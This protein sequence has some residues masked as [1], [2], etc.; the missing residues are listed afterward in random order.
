[1]KK[2]FSILVLTL[3]VNFLALAGGIGYLYGTKKLDKDKVHAIRD[4]VFPTTAPSDADATTQPSDG[5]PTTRS[6]FGLDEVLATHAG[7]PAAEQVQLVHRT[8]DFRV[9]DLE[10]R[11]S[12]LNALH[13][14]VKN[15]ETKLKS[16]REAFEAQRKALETREQEAT[17]LASDKG[18]QDALKLYGTMKPKQIK[19]VFVGLSDEVVVRYMRAMEPR[20][21]SKI[22]KEFKTPAELER[23]KVLMEQVRSAEASVSAKQ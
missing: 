21:V 5:G 3:A 12:E 8:A 7:M 16:E 4:I 11:Q 13:D 9:A 18:F 1:V 2:I 22:L 10:R 17:R 15:A 23:V 6:T 19:D 14:L 20:Q